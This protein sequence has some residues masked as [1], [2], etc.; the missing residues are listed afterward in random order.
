M[1]SLRWGILATGR[2]A[3]KFA[4]ELPHASG[5][6]FVAVGSRSQEAADHFAKD[7]GVRA[8]GSYEALLGDK[9]VDAIYLSTPHPSHAEWAIAAAR[10]GKHI[11]CEKP[12]TMNHREAVAV[13]EAAREHRVFLMEAFM[14]RCHPRT[15]QF[16]HLIRSGAIG[17]PSLIEASFAFVTPFNPASRLYAKELGGG[18]ILDVGCYTTSIAR[19]AAGAAFG[20]PFADPESVQGHAVF[21]ETGVDSLATATLKFPSGLL[22]NISCGFL[23]RADN[24]LRVYGS[25][26]SLRVADFWKSS[27][28]IELFENASGQIRRIEV[29]DHPH[30]YALEAEA[31]AAALPDLESPLVS[32]ND[33]LGNMKTL[34]AWRQSAGVRYDCDLL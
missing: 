10:A 6:R 29:P 18:S 24:S 30:L 33:T 25:E 12:L 20:E 19:L 3:R 11:L 14:Y 9:E 4:E 21:A 2:I 23:A 16:A 28:S 34:D 17:I 22:A 13:V 1:H 31:V 8:H 26:G 32:W 27:E 15:A 5:Q 7:F